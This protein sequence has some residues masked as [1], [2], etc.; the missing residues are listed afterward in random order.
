MYSS[1]SFKDDSSNLFNAPCILNSK[2]CVS[3]TQIGT[4]NFSDFS[5][6]AVANRKVE[7]RNA[8]KINTVRFMVISIEGLTKL[9]LSM[10]D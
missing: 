5:S 3:D 1:G 8:Q 10:I 6:L 2:H 4:L 7:A 9:G